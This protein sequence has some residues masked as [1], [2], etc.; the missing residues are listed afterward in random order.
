[1]ED[2]M[3]DEQMPRPPASVIPTGPGYP[4]TDLPTFYA[5]GIANVA[6]SPAV[7]RF[8]LY[9]SD[10]E[11]AGKPE[12]KN[13]IIA[14]IVMPTTAFAFAGLF[15]ESSVRRLAEQGIIPKELYTMIKNEIG[16]QDAADKPP[17]L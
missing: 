11:M 17:P 16:M 10:P 9:R 12:Y 7:V 15:L 6:P 5:D 2:A 3:T 4:P 14:Q 8:Y 1:L 13:Q